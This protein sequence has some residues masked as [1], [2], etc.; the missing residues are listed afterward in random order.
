[1]AQP[2]QDPNVFLESSGSNDGVQF[3]IYSDAISGRKW[4][5]EGSCN[6]CGACWV[7]S[8]TESI[9]WT[10]TP[11]GEPGAFIDLREEPRLDCPVTPKIKEDIEC[12]VLNGRY[13]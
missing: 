13:I 3:V 9:G 11:I 8:P 10:G 6:M 1:V 4:V 7:G 2:T 5:I 12:C